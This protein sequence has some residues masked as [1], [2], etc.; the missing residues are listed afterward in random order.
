[1]PRITVR[2]RPTHHYGIPLLSKS[3]G[4]N[5]IA[6]RGDDIVVRLTTDAPLSYIDREAPFRTDAAATFG[7]RDRRAIPGE[8]FRRTC[9]EFADRTRDYWTELGAA[10]SIAYDWQD[11]II[12]AAITLKLSN[13]EETGGIIAAH[14]T[15]IPEAPGPGEPGTIAIAGCETHISSSR[16]SIALAPPRP[17]RISSPSFSGSRRKTLIRPVYSIVPTDRMDEEI[18]DAPRR[19][20]AAMGRC[21]SAMP[22][23]SRASTTPMAASSS[24][25]CRCSSTAGCRGRAMRDLFHLLERLGHIARAIGVRAGRRHLGISR[26]RSVSTPIRRPCAGPAAVGWPPSQHIWGSR[27]APRT[28]PA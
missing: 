27:I 15:S 22:R 13:F 11:V 8:I 9:R 4:S 21:A 10:P 17:W 24:P 18:A 12:R 5:H 19:A 20:I 6:F 28:G 16:H 14:T 7:N 2:F 23:W 1:M 3:I 26:P 25:P